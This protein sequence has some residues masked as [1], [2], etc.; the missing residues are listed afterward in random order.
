MAKRGGSRQSSP[1]EGQAVRG[2]SQRQ[3]R[4]GEELRHRLAAA[5]ERDLLNDPA[6]VGV[7]IT[8]T[9]VKVSPDLSNAT[10]YVTPLGGGD[11]VAVVKALNHASGF[12]RHTVSEDLGLRVSPRLTF[13]ADLSFEVASRVEAIL[14]HPKVAGDIAREDPAPAALDPDAEDDDGPA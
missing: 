9:E 12:L 14:K 1:P 7:V 6:L 13:A 8:V 2:R 10:C 11:M 3:L 5:F 4:V